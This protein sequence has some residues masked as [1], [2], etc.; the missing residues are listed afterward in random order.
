[1]PVRVLINT[2]TDY[3]P[4]SLLLGLGVACA[5]VSEWVWRY[6]VRHYTSASS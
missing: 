3:R 4:L 2:L 6:S 1:V 5:A